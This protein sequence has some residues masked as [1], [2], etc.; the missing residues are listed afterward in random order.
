MSDDNKVPYR[1]TIE[2]AVPM[3]GVDGR[4]IQVTGITDLTGDPSD[5][6]ELTRMASKALADQSALMDAAV[7]QTE[8]VDRQEQAAQFDGAAELLNMPTSR[9]VN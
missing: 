6:R 7:K 2:L 4:T 5:D 1:I 3:E 9:T 8:A